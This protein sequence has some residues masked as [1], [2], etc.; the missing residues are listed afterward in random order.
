[1]GNDVRIYRAMNFQTIRLT[2]FLFRLLFP[3]VTGCLFQN[4]DM[5]G[6]G[7]NSILYIRN[8]PPDT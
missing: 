4:S 5:D 8:G 7:A 3:I 2:I 6:F 1:M